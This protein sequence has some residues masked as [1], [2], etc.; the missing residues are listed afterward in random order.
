M[1]D[2]CAC[3]GKALKFLLMGFAVLSI[4]T[5]IYKIAETPRTAPAA[6]S[7]E[8]ATPSAKMKHPPALAAKKSAETAVKTKTAVV[9][10]FYTNTRCS[11]CMAIE[12]YTREAIEKNFAS[13][14]KGWKVFFKGINIEEEDNGH[15]ADDYR[16]SSKSVVV[17]KFSEDQA[18]EWERLE[19]IWQ[20]LGDKD[21]FMNYV[22]DETHKML[23]KK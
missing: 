15:F 18:L 16:L 6:L 7:A 11:S 23:D 14:Y 2:Q 20:L 19:K 8:T 22:T 5:T 4:V 3:G 13:G 10:Y 12:A 9:Y 21:A 1:A 17:Q